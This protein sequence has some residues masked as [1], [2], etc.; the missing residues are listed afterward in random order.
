MARQIESLHSAVRRVAGS[1]PTEKTRRAYLVYPY[2]DGQ[3]MTAV[4]FSDP[5]YNTAGTTVRA[6]IS[7]GFTVP[8]SLTVIPS[9]DAGYPVTVVVRRGQVTVVGF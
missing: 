3:L 8:G 5:R 9:L 2:R 4:C 6:R 1:L 7:A